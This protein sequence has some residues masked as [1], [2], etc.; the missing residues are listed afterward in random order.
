MI[1]GTGIDIL[2]IGRLRKALERWPRL[3]ERLFS[4]AELASCSSSRMK[5]ARLAGRFAAKEAVAKA[6]G[7]PLSWRD[8]EIANDSR[9]KPTASFSPG[10]PT[11]TH[12]VEV[13]VSISHG[14]EYAVAHALALRV[15]AGQESDNDC[16]ERT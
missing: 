15:S 1:I 16:G 14:K 11:S 6:L 9:G 13:M 5:F 12:G 10:A 7:E 4:P 2:E 8:V 3:S